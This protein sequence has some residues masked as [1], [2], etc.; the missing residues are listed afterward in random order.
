MSRSLLSTGR[1]K[2]W[3]AVSAGECCE[4]RGSR[5][6]GSR[7]REDGARECCDLTGECAVRGKGR[8]IFTCQV[9]VLGRLALIPPTLF[10]Q[11]PSLRREKREGLENLEGRPNADRR[12]PL[13]SRR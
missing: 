6:P 8:D 9:C 13:F 3:R 11:P 7:R 4:S 10:S 1:R 5:S 12:V 2:L